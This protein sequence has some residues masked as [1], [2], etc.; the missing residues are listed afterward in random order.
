MM[1]EAL[2]HPAP[3]YLSRHMDSALV[4][5]TVA[6]PECLL[7]SVNLYKSCSFY[8]I[9]YYSSSNSASTTLAYL[10]YPEEVIKGYFILLAFPHDFSNHS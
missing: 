6:F 4:Y 10:N 1:S 3:S 2:C 8:L 5:Q 9:Q 7:M